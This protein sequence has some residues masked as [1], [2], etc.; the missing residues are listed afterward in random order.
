MSVRADRS[1]Y[2]DLL[3]D[4][5]RAADDATPAIL[6][7]VAAACERNVAPAHTARLAR[8]RRLIENGA[9][10]EAGLAM[11]ELELPRWKLR[12]LVYDQGDWHCALSSQRELPEWLDQAVEASHRNLALAILAAF[13]DALRRTAGEARIGQPSVPQI[14][15][16]TYTYAP[17]LCENFD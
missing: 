3:A 4:Q 8:L 5:V 7:G 2:L 14:H 17:L 11:I 15:F 12:R 16:H 1:R 13:V 9:S 10:A 6:S